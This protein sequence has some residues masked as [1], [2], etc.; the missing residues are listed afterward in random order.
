MIRNYAYNI[1]RL[2][3][4]SKTIGG[5]KWTTNSRVANRAD[6]E[7]KFDRDGGK[8]DSDKR[9]MR[10]CRQIR[11]GLSVRYRKQDEGNRNRKPIAYAN[12][13]TSK[14]RNNALILRID[15]EL[16]PAKRDGKQWKK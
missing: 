7:K 15:D 12:A 14:T 2:L 8:S 9:G 16:Q 5:G 4:R 1:A 6:A 3:E 13:N 10:C 11:I